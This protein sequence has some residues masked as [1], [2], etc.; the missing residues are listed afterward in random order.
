M[1]GD[2][3]G[4]QFTMVNEIKQNN[5]PKTIISPPVFW[6]QQEELLI[7]WNNYQML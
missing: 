2:V 5:A 7:K 1:S 4:N 6:L 3:S